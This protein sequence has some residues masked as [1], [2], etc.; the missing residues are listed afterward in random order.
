MCVCLCLA[1][2]YRPLLIGL[3]RVTPNLALHM[4][5]DRRPVSVS[6]R[7]HG[8]QVHMRA[9][10]EPNGDVASRTWRIAISTEGGPQA[11]PVRLLL[12]GGPS[13]HTAFTRSTPCTPH[14]RHALSTSTRLHHPRGDSGPAL[15]PL[16]TP[17]AQLHALTTRH[18]VWNA[19][20]HALGPHV[21]SLEGCERGKSVQ[22]NGAYAP[23][24]RAS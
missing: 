15:L 23:V 3:S 19:C 7:V 11:L 10:G 9:V 20:A 18:S 4:R 2:C 22:G 5:S 6:M 17:G 21:P 8:P 13:R 14:R 16:Q 12:A 1:V 24:G